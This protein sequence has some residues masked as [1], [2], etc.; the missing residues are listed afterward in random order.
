MLPESALPAYEQEIDHAGLIRGW[1]VKSLAR[2][3]AIYQQICQNCHGDLNVPGTLPTSLRFGQGVFQHG[4]DPYTIYQTL[5]RGWRL[6]LPQVDLVPQEKYDVIHY[7]REYFLKEHNRAQWFEVTPAY[8][9]G[10]PQGSSHGPAPVKREPWRE[11]D[12]GSFL[13]GTFEIMSPGRRE[14]KRPAGSPPDYVA[15]DANLAYKAIALRLDPGPGGVAAGSTWLAFEHDTLRVAGV[16]TGEG[17]I[18]WHAINFD[19][20]HVVRPRTIGTLL[21]ETGDVPGWA[22]PAT[23]KFDDPRLRGLDQRPYGPLPQAWGRY[24][25]LYRQGAR[26]VVSYTVGDAAVLEGYALTAGGR[27]TVVR[28][29]NVGISSRDLAVRLGN[30]GTPITLR[31]PAGVTQQTEAG[32][33]VVHIPA[34]L[35]PLRLAAAYGQ[36]AAE[37]PEPAD[38]TPFTYGGPASWP[39]KIETA[40]I[41]GPTGGPLVADS[42][43]L[44]ARAA[45]PLKSWMRTT[46]LDFVPGADAALVCTWD[47]E[48]WRVDG[49]AGDHATVTWR[50]IAAGLFQPLGLKIVHGE[51]FVSC[52]D[53]IVH[54]RDL[55]GDGE[56]DFYA[57][58]NSDHQVTEHFHEFAMG[59]QADDAGNFY[60][61]KSARHARTALVPQHGTLLKVSADGARTEILANGFRAANGVCLNPDGSFIVTDQEGFW[62]PMNRINWVKP[63]GFYGN[64]WSYGA[65]ADARDAAMLPPLTWIDKQF[66]RSPAELLWVPAGVWGPLQGKL[67]NLSYGRGFIE[68]VPFETIGGLQQGG[69]AVLP[70]PEF[71]TGIMRGRFLPGSGQLFV[72]G[73]SAWATDQLHMPGGFYR[74]S[75]TGKPLH[76]PVGLHARQGS[77]EI[78]F[79]DPLDP[80]SI[81]E[82]AKLS[83][84]T[85]SLHRSEKYG[86]PRQNVKQLKIAGTTLSPDGRTLRLAL[87]EIEPV[88]QMEVRYDLK[89]PRGEAV[90]GTFENTIHRLGAGP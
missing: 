59:L 79:S 23:G 63:G 7:L 16:W 80:A 34:R 2:G 60:Y 3:R 78:T 90:T 62:M 9:A 64:M 49:I 67:L 17:F 21:A 22:N 83:V 54:L 33:E 15:P 89:G 4:N 18:D 74:I 27:P 6:M 37:V 44:P 38:L 39:E 10:L 66:D 28:T 88:W 13:I 87:P 47:G 53:Q 50:R 84:T 73:M 26:T 70:L 8:L 25:G 46:G 24:R 5:T 1:D 35:T 52:R 68:V 72:C 32:F 43:A 36:P 69:V 55:N 58:F 45:N 51:I 29:L 30:A 40:V 82:G 14:A 77:L 76:V 48:V 11:M 85:W 56:A 57:C 41:R 81:G 20:Q 31:A 42:L 19:G 65:P 75:A 12:Y 71:P 61:A 86:S